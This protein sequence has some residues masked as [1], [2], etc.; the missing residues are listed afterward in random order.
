VPPI[1]ITPGGT[2]RA[3]S[4]NVA[5]LGYVSMLTA[6]SSAMIYGLLPMF[7]VRVLGLGMVSVGLIEGI[8]ESAN[9]LASFCLEMPGFSRWPLRFIDKVGT[10]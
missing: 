8:A 2:R 6:L 3:L 4:P 1:I 7:L 5:V 9:S 10:Q